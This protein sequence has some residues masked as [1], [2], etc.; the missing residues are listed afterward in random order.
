LLVFSSPQA[1]E[2]SQQF[3]RPPD[4]DKHHGKGESLLG[5]C[6]MNDHGPSSPLSSSIVMEDNNNKQLLQSLLRLLA[7]AII[8]LQF[9]ATIN[10]ARMSVARLDCSATML[11]ASNDQ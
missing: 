7:R 11:P 10:K 1:N 2:K 8:D 6:F 4:F 3:L 5:L 9:H